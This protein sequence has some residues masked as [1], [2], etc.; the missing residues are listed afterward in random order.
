MADMSKD[1]FLT[2]MRN[3]TARDAAI[4][5]KLLGEQDTRWR[6]A[7]GAVTKQ[8]IEGVVEAIPEATL[9]AKAV[10]KIAQSVVDNLPETDELSIDDLLNEAGR[11][12][13]SEAG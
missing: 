6:M 12:L 9:D 11:R 1:D 8:I 5:A 10:D 3:I 7:M 2:E 4:T 13:D